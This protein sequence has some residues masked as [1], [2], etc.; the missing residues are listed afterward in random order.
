MSKLTANVL[1]LQKN[2]VQ[3]RESYRNKILKEET[4][5]MNLEI[6]ILVRMKSFFFTR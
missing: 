6:E 4:Q 3:N 1:D 5:L 2:V